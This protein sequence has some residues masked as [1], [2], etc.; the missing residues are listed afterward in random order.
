M[1]SLVEP[2]EQLELAAALKS[3]APN[4]ARQ[5]IAV[6][7]LHLLSFRLSVSLPSI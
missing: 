7:S 4:V 5:K 2:L 1:V 6:G 3:D